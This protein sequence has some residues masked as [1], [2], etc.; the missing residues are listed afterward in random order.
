M[1]F[2]PPGR[3]LMLGSE[4]LEAIPERGG[5]VIPTSADGG[6]SSILDLLI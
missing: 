1:L 5:G 4:W 2:G 6:G 3:P